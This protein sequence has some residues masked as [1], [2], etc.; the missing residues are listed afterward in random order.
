M[1]DIN[2]ML[3]QAA[4]YIVAGVVILAMVAIVVFAGWTIWGL[5]Q[6]LGGYGF[7]FLVL[8]FTVIGTILWAFDR[9]F[10]GR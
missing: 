5:Y 8:L 3:D 7:T 2:I 4:E 9:I 1:K 6:F 10:N